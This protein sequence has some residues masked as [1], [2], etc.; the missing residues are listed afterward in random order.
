[1]LITKYIRYYSNMS[2]EPI[3]LIHG[4]AGNISDARVPGKIEGM[5]CALRSAIDYLVPKEEGKVGNALDAVEAAVKMME[6]NDNFNAGYGSVLNL[7]GYTEVEASIMDG[8]NLKAGCVTLLRD[9]MHPVSVARRVMEQTNHTFLG[10]EAAQKF[11]IKQGFEQLA[12]IIMMNI[13]LKKL[14]YFRIKVCI[15]RGIF[16]YG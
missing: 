7:D 15:F 5:K 11:A 12:G 3:L 14:E 4:G 1:M 8:A 9:I 16:N 6:I 10:G 13:K 2:I